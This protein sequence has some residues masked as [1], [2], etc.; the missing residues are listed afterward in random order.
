LEAVSKRLLHTTDWRIL[1]QGGVRQTLK[2][3]VNEW[4]LSQPVAVLA[5]RAV[6]PRKMTCPENLSCDS[7]AN[8]QILA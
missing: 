4:F 1:G 6:F 7:A 3:V 5:G 8:R 2:R